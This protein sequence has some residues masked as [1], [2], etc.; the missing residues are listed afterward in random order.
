MGFMAGNKSTS[1]MSTRTLGRRAKKRKQTNLTR[2]VGEEHDK[3][4]DTHSPTS[5]GRETMFQPDNENEFGHKPP[6]ISPSNADLRVY[7]SL[8]DWL[9]LIV[10]LFLLSSLGGRTRQ[11]TSIVPR[12]TSWKRTCSSKRD[13]CSNGSFNSVYALQISLPHRNASQRSH[14]PG[15]DR[16]FFARSDMT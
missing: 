6:R 13:R 14:R 16:W 4:V 1:L 10:T 9:C 8:I 5:S 2:R 11:T 7:K 15:R 3:S 12:V